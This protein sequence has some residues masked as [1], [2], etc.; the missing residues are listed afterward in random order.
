MAK[1]GGEVCGPTQAWI[2]AA[3]PVPVFSL[4]VLYATPEFFPNW[5]LP[6]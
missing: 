5:L 4:G 1:I 6:F 3:R 2:D